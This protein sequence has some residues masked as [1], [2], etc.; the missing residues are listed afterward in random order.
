MA[1]Y[2]S[3]RAHGHFVRRYR[4]PRFEKGI[5]RGVFRLL[6]GILGFS[7]R[8]FALERRGFPGGNGSPSVARGGRDRHVK[9]AH[10]AGAGVRAVRNL[11]PFLRGVLQKGFLFVDVVRLFGKNGAFAVRRGRAGVSVLRRIRLRPLLSGFQ[12]F[13]NRHFRLPGLAL[14]QRFLGRFFGYR[15]FFI[16]RNHSVFPGR[17]QNGVNR[18]PFS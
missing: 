3:V 15:A 13:R 14:V 18:R 6:R 7:H 10:D 2:E 8:R 9:L 5:R 1:A 12:R 17:P 11:C 4:A 16:R